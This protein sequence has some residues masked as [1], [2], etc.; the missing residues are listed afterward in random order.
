MIRERAG[1]AAMAELIEAIGEGAARQLAKKL[2]GTTVYVPLA[3]GEHHPLCVVLGREGADRL[4]G[5][6][7]GLRIAVPKQA[8]RR[9]RVLELHR[10]ALTSAEIAA[11]TGYSQRHVFRLLREDADDRQP[12]LFG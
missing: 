7:G 2:G 5:W 10:R 8:E 6:A 11:E 9:A 1:D 12:D 3:I 4:R